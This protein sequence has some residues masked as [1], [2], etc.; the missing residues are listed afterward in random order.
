MGTLI[1]I[2]SLP[3]YGPLVQIEMGTAI[4]AVSL[5]TGIALGLQVSEE[6]PSGLILRTFLASLGAIAIVA[7]TVLAP[8]LAGVV[9]TLD[10]V[11]PSGSARLGA[12]FTALFIVPVHILGGVIGFG[13][14]DLFAP[15]QFGG[16]KGRLESR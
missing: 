12:L 11:A 8:M 6:E 15:A 3:E 10:V 13:L 9:P 16:R 5:I 1:G 7:V 4:I 14:A 2:A